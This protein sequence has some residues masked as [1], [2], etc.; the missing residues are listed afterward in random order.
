MLSIVQIKKYLDGK[1]FMHAHKGFVYLA[2]AIKT[3]KE[4]STYRNKITAL[5]AL[6]GKKND[7]TLRSVERAIRHSIETSDVCGTTNSEFIAKALDDLEE[8]EA[9]K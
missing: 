8:M 4:D 2:E 7:S 9:E 3:C 6:I 5:Y 1:G